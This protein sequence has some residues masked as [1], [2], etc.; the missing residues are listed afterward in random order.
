MI[1]TRAN[2]RI[3]T[4]TSNIIVLQFCEYNFALKTRCTH[5]LFAAVESFKSMQLRKIACFAPIIT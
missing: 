1:L 2:N 3:H 5:I 4:D